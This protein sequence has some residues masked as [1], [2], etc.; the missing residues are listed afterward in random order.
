MAFV[1]ALWSAI[2]IFAFGQSWDAASSR[3]A[4][5]VEQRSAPCSPASPHHL[6][7]LGPSLA[8]PLGAGSI[9]PF[10]PVG[11]QGQRQSL[12][13]AT[14]RTLRFCLLLS[15]FSDLVYSCFTVIRRL[16]RHRRHVHYTLLPRSLQNNTT[17]IMGLY[18]LSFICPTDTPFP[19]L[20]SETVLNECNKANDTTHLIRIT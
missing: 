4:N 3:V 15:S 17:T 18:E 10:L 5:P 13:C 8:I 7:I 12:S 14:Q 16:N 1:L 9:G 20:I 19:E 6:A 11:R 2:P